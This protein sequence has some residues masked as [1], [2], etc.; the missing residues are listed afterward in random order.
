MARVLLTCAATMR[1]VS[2]LPWMT[3]DINNTQQ[4]F[5][6]IPSLVSTR[7]L[8]PPCCNRPFGRG[9]LYH[10]SEMSMVIEND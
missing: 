5:V 2:Q 6:T 1:T 7:Y 4:K 10:G 8:D 3:T 9:D